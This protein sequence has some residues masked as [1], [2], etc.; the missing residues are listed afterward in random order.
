[1]MHWSRPYR[2]YPPPPAANHGPHCADT[3]PPPAD[4]FKLGHY[5]AR[6]VGKRTVGILLQCFPVRLTICPTRNSTGQRIPSTGLPDGK[7]RFFP[8]Q[9]Q[10][11]A[12]WFVLISRYTAY[13]VTM[14]PKSL[15]NLTQPRST[16]R[17]FL[18]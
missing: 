15:L 1:M 7:T 8:N 6:M 3:P 4:T 11:Y 17:F 18:R 14:L 16:W 5:E 12:V 2:D 10:T 9:M 13:L